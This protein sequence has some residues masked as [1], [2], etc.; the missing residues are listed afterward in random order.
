[1]SFFFFFPLFKNLERQ[2]VTKT[3]QDQRQSPETVIKQVIKWQSMHIC[4]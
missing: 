4:Q 3:K 2:K 1:M